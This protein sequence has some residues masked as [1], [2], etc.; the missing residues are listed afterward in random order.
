MMVTGIFRTPKPDEL[1]KTL[2]NVVTLV[3]YVII[4]V[5]LLIALTVADE[6][7]RGVERGTLGWL[8]RNGMDLR[9][10]GTYVAL[11]AG[12]SAVLWHR[13][14][15][16]WLASILLLFFVSTPYLFYTSAATYYLTTESNASNVALVIYWGGYTFCFLLI[17]LI[18]LLITW[19]E[20]TRLK[21]VD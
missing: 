2:H 14:R 20:V 12:I 8:K 19:L 16:Y 15:K 21:G 1:R 5:I 3:P 11:T 7:S 6:Q 18:A 17:A 4:V 9:I 10:F 13:A